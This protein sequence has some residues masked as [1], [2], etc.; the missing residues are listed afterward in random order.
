MKVETCKK[1]A[2]VIGTSSKLLALG[3][4]ITFIIGSCF[5]IAVDKKQEKKK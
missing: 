1:C 3:S 2:N 4:L 5:A